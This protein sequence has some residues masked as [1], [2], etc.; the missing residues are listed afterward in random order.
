MSLRV[1]TVDLTKARIGF[2]E[3]SS[4]QQTESL[5]R[6]NVLQKSRQTKLLFHALPNCKAKSTL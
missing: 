5:I 6:T 2:V 3:D 4:S 1:Y